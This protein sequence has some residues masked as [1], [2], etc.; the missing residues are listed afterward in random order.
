MKRGRGSRVDAFDDGVNVV[1]LQQDLG[2][3]RRRMLRLGERVHLCSLGGKVRRRRFGCA[4]CEVAEGAEIR[5]SYIGSKTGDWCRGR[6]SRG[7]WLEPRAELPPE[8]EAN[9]GKMDPRMAA[10]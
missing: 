3:R 10:V 8:T 2:Q 5:A 6:G 7:A 1:V 4:G 9:D